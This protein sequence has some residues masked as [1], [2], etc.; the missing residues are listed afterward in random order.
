MRRRL[1]YVEGMRGVAALIVCIAH[2][3]QI[4]LPVVYEGDVA[5]SW[6]VGEHA[7]ETSPM[8]VVVN[9][10]FSVCLFFVLSGYVLSQ[11]FMADGKLSR[12]WKAAIKRFPRLMLPVLGSVLLAWAVL[13]AG[14]FHYGELKPLSGAVMPDYFAS[15]RSFLYALGAGSYGA[16]FTGDGSLN[17]V[18]WTIQVEFY[19]SFLVF[20]L[21]VAF[22]RSRYRWLGY[23][24]TALLLYDGY[25]LAFPIGVA[26]AALRLP[27]LTRPAPA[28]ALLVLGLALGSYPYYGADEGFWRWL[29]TPGSALPIVFH[30]TLGA[31]LLLV[32]VILS[33]YK[34][35]FDR[36]AF[37]FLGRISYSLY[38]IHFT[39]LAA[40]PTWLVL[41][42]QPSLDYLPAIAI[43][44]AVTLPALLIAAYGYAR[45][46]DE[47]ATRL[48][49]RFAIGILA[50]IPAIG[51][52]LRPSTRDVGSPSPP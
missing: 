32:A 21:L 12:I 24:I 17:P 9:P 46:V 38:L 15:P 50:I 44:F 35:V 1:G 26:I 39:I 48:A 40:V 29:P 42:L 16:F 51:S 27:T 37:R 20:F 47:P 4:F 52:R 11:G 8:N 41:R 14:G 33:P 10:N 23:G 49:D 6:G 22:R 45:V 7:F 25:Y 31:A 28:A 13:T 2:F 18:L 3:L 36:Q 5:K 30:H 19:G 43:A 34:A